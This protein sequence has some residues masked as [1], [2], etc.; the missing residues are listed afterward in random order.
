MTRREPIFNVPGVVLAMLGLLGIVHAVRTWALSDETDAVATI[1][2]AMVPAR[3][4]GL[5]EQL[6][7]G[8]ASAWYS[9]LTHMLVHADATHLGVNAIWLLIFGTI[10][11]RRLGLA[12]MLVFTILTGLIAAA[13]FVAGNWGA[14][15]PMVGASGAVSGL[16]GGAIRLLH[17]I[18]RV[19]AMREAATAADYVPLASIGETLRD[20]S[21]LV[22]IAVTIGVNIALGA[23]GSLL[24]PGNEGIAWEA[25]LGGFVAGLLGFG[26]IDPGP[27]PFPRHPQEFPEVQEPV[28]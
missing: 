1:A 17:S 7:G 22:I 15:L 19:G 26:L 8:I 21:V 24:A 12:R 3:Y 16:M 13:T 9:P 20:R 6:P 23:S 2:M 18:M 10:V 4:A 14:L 25:H 28:A 5:A 27:K 11:A